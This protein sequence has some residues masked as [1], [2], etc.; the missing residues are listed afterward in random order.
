MKQTK[1]PFFHFL[2]HD[3]VRVSAY[4]QHSF[5]ISDFI[6]FSTFIRKE[7][8]FFLSLFSL[9]IFRLLLFCIHAAKSDISRSVEDEFG[10]FLDTNRKTDKNKK[11][12]PTNSLKKGFKQ[13][14]FVKCHVH[15]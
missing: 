10:D 8:T 6:I 3:I 13:N 11:E 5:Q 7:L 2:N 9:K 15:T 12:T 4:Q 1:P 14:S